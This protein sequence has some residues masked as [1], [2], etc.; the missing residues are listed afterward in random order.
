MTTQAWQGVFF[1]WLS[2]KGHLQGMHG[3]MRTE[4]FATANGNQVKA[5]FIVIWTQ[6]AELAAWLEHGYSI[7]EMLSSMDVAADAI[8]TSVGRD[9]S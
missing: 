1:S 6:E 8:T 9:F 4:L 7:E 3:L 5:T 2:L